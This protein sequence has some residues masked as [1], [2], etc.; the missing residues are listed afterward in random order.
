M[1]IQ[2]S[3]ED[4]EVIKQCEIESL[5]QRSIPIGTIFGVA[6]FAAIKRGLLQPSAKFGNTPKIVGA[7]ILGYIVGKLSYQQV[8]AEKL[9]RLPNSQVGEMLRRRKGGFMENFSSDGGLSMAPFSLVSINLKIK[10]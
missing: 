10:D 7:C 8:C 4:M 5:I 2:F 6:T 1:G 3:A 9:M